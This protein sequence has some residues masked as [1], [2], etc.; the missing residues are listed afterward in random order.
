MK[1]TETQLRKVIRKQIK[2]LS[3]YGQIT[4]RSNLFGVTFVIS[5]DEVD[6]KTI[7]VFYPERK[8][9]GM[10]VDKM[11]NQLQKLLTKKLGKATRQKQ[12][13]APAIRFSINDVGITEK[14]LKKL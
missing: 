10:D 12:Q 6:N 5:A 3:G 14:D 8:A 2:E 11:A 9:Y 1:L 7:I 4:V 13:T